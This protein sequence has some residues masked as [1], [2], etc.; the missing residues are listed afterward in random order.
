MVYSWLETYMDCGYTETQFWNSTIA[1]VSRAIESYNRV[2]ITKQKEKAVYDY[3]LADL[4]GKSISRIFSDD[5]TYPELYE[6]Y[7][8]LFDGKQAQE[9]KQRKKDELSIIRFKQFAK[10]HNEKF[11]K[12]VGEK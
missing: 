7:P 12:E 11:N 5:I 6:Q 4:I 3:L 8:L 2:L 9:E 1:E 10:A